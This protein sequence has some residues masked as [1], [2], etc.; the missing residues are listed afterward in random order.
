MQKQQ[1]RNQIKRYVEKFKEYSGT[2]KNFEVIFDYVNFIKKEPYLNKLFKDNLNYSN[3]EIAKLKKILEENPEIMKK[4]EDYSFDL[5]NV[6]KNPSSPVFNDIFS[7]YFE[8]YK[9]RE[10]LPLLTNLPVYTANLKIIYDQIKDIKKAKKNNNIKSAQEI[11]NNLKEDSFTTITVKNKDGKDITV[12]SNRY[13]GTCMEMTA[14]YFLDQIDGELFLENNK[15]KKELYF[16]KEKSI[17]HIRGDE[18]VITR[19]NEKST[20]HYILQ[21]L[22]DSDDLLEQADFSEIS[23]DLMEKE[24]YHWNTYRSACDRLNQKIAEITNIKDFIIYTTGRTGWCK[25]NE[26]YI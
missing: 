20:E 21:A 4:L 1:I 22:F 7:K 14:K 19:K 12:T 2:F 13:L 3:K 6:D 8:A 24:T 16:D 18:I 15:Q 10:D 26:K 23:Q 17:L 9:I 25:I 5:K 11:I